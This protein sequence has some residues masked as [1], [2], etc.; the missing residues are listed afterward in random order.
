MEIA[1]EFIWQLIIF[2]FMCVVIVAAVILGHVVRNF[3]D[4]MKKK[5]EEKNQTEAVEKTE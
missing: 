3:V 5:K 4:K 2:L 1:R